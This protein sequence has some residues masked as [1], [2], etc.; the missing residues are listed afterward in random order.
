MFIPPLN[1]GGVLVV[2]PSSKRDRPPS[3]RNFREYQE[4]TK[5][6]S[7]EVTRWACNRAGGVPFEYPE[8]IWGYR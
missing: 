6:F 5:R 4:P 8:R 7:A 1:Q 2:V 3:P